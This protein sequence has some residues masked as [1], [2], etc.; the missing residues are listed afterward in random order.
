MGEDIQNGVVEATAL[1]AR[2]RA[3]LSPDA[4]FEASQ[5]AAMDLL[6]AVGQAAKTAGYEAGLERGALVISLRHRGAAFVAV[7]DNPSPIK[8]LVGVYGS[9][10]ED[11][12]VEY[13]PFLQRYIGLEEDKTRHPV[14]GARTPRR[15]AVEVVAEHVLAKIGEADK[16]RRTER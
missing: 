10:A 9:S 15:N 6:Q 1:F 3:K 16:V 8:I 7:D 5:K 13:D 2:T 11:A 14:P 4:V 12:K